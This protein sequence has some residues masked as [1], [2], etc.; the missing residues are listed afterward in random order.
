MSGKHLSCAKGQ[1]VLNGIHFR[2]WETKNVNVL[3]GSFTNGIF[4]SLKTVN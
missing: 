2:F 1:E 4:L 3:I